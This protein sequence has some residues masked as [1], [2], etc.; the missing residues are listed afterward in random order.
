MYVC[1]ITLATQCTCG[2]PHASAAGSQ[3]GAA[4]V[5]SIFVHYYCTQKSNSA[6]IALGAAYIR[7]NHQFILEISI[8]TISGGGLVFCELIPVSKIPI[9]ELNNC[10]FSFSFVGTLVQSTKRSTFQLNTYYIYIFPNHRLK[11]N[12][13]L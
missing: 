12:I 10:F 1:V 5:R 3:Q 11:M 7:S 6:T 2:R 9:N 13:F 4:R 8:S